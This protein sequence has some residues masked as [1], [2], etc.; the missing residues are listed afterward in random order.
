MNLLGF[1]MQDNR[2]EMKFTVLRR[3]LPWTKEEVGLLCN[4]IFN[5]VY[6]HPNH[7]GVVIMYGEHSQEKIAEILS[8]DFG[9]YEVVQG[10]DNPKLPFRPTF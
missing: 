2:R 9:E 1:I 10:Y 5:E 4:G 3:Q 6:E 8:G 7:P